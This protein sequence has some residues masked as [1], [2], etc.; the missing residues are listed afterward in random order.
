MRIAYCLL[1]AA[2]APHL[3]LAQ[4]LAALRATTVGTLFFVSGFQMMGDPVQAG[5]RLYTYKDGTISLFPN[6]HDL[7][8]YDISDDGTV[9]A[10]NGSATSTIVNSGGHEWMR[11][12]SASIRLSANGLYAAIQTRGGSVSMVDIAARCTLWTIDSA[13]VL[14][15]RAVSGNGVVAALQ[16]QQPVLLRNGQ[17][18][19]IKLD[20]RVSPAISVSLQEDGEGMAVLADSRVYLTSFVS[21]ETTPLPLIGV[22]DILRYTPAT[23]LCVRRTDVVRFP[24]DAGRP[25]VLVSVPAGILSAAATPDGQTIFTG[26]E[27]RIQ[28]HANGDSST[29]ASF[30]FLPSVGKS[31]LGAIATW[32]IPPGLPLIPAF[33]AEPPF[34]LS[35]AG[36]RITVGGIP[37]PLHSVRH[38][39]SGRNL[40]PS[41]EIRFLVPWN[42]SFSGQRK[43][44]PIVLLTP[45]GTP[46][47]GPVAPQFQ[48]VRRDPK[49]EKTPGFLRAFLITGQEIDSANPAMAG[50]RI[51]LIMSG[52]GDVSPLP[53]NDRPPVVPTSLIAPMECYVSNGIESRKT[54]PES[55]SLSLSQPGIFD[56]IL[57]LPPLLTAGEFYIGCEV[58]GFGDSGV[59]PARR[60]Q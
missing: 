60:P 1:V 29:I 45:E 42:L 44:L 5:Q 7:I 33:E 12:E 31:A 24:L 32:H 20:L 14:T 56:V 43:I 35:V 6:S 21:T 26:T 16:N 4:S 9:I 17:S 53:P 57:T 54:I 3:C 25:E 47:A 39:P 8:G 22:T 2:V 50:S 46:L 51:R 40:P 19:P 27:S 55:V 37:A 49:F 23:L 28:M 48:L 18:H 38:V 52:L 59:I 15:G 36:Y 58:E 34:P 10:L 30:Y 41:N 11:F 13:I